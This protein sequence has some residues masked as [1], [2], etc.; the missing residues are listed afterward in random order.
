MSEQQAESAQTISPRMRLLGLGLILALQLLYIPINRI[1]QEGVVLR[2]PWDDFIPLWPIWTIPYL[3]SIAWWLG[4]SIWA[5]W[6]MDDR[7]YL[8]FVAAAVAVMLIGYGIHLLYPT[9]VERPIL[10]GDT[11]Q[12]RLLSLVYELD[13]G[14]NA[15]PSGHTYNTILISLFWYRWQPRHRALALGIAIIVLLSTLFTGQ[16]NL[17]DLVG[18]AV[19]A[20]LGY[21]FGLWWAA[22]QLASE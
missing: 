12:T 4:F 1:L 15:F 6:K 10:T 7:L 20:W 11:W 21:R 13:R 22:R 3:L 5:T 16:H 2:T 8:A 18:G 19:L 17:P 9:C 14:Y